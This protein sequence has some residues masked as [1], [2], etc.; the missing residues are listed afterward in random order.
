MKSPADLTHR[1]HSNESYML[2]FWGTIRIVAE[3]ARVPI[4]GARYG[5]PLYFARY[6]IID[7]IADRP[8]YRLKSD[9]DRHAGRRD[10]ACLLLR[11]C[12][13]PARC[14]AVVCTNVKCFVHHSQTATKV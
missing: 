14:L 8:G 7:A 10:S 13:V 2:A 11:R 4:I 9:I 1:T 3:R 12:L 5:L 6:A